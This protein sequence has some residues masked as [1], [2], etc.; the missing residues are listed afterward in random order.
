MGKSEILCKWCKVFIP[1][2]NY[3]NHVEDKHKPSIEDK[4]IA[5]ITSSKGKVEWVL[6]NFPAT[7][8]N[9]G[10][11]CTKV[12]T[13]FPFKSARCIYTPST[14]S[15]ELHADSY[16]DFFYAIKHVSTLTRLSRAIRSANPELAGS[17]QKE[18]ERE[19]QFGQSKHVWAKGIV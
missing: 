19:I 8:S 10:L 3:F 6:K 11:L 16:D 5:A 12:F 17:P 15:M 18:L 1:E 2:A 4:V 13:Y 14:G 9:E 7:R